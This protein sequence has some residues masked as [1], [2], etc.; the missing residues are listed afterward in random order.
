MI[1]E[2]AEA[3][4]IRQMLTL[5]HIAS[6]SCSPGYGGRARAVWCLQIGG[7]EVN[8]RPGAGGVQHQADDRAGVIGDSGAQVR[9][10]QG[11]GVVVPGGN[12]VEVLSSQRRSQPR[13]ERKRDLLLWKTSGKNRAGVPSAMRRVQQD[14]GARLRAEDRRRAEQEDG[15]E[16]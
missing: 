15:C 6:L 14:R 8:A 4:A 16:F 10:R 11:C 12:D 9:I 1:R 3:E 2:K 7:V 13:G 5:R